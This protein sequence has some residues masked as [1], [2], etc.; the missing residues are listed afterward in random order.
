MNRITRLDGGLGMS[1]IATHNGTVYLAGWMGQAS[2][3]IT[4]AQ[5]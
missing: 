2:D 5:S 1:Q 3:E 4:V